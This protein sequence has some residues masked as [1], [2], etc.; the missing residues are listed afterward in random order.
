MGVV[1]TD[2][3]RFEFQE[4]KEVLVWYTAIYRPVSSTALANI[5]FP[6]TTTFH[7]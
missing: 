7:E 6:Y 4:Q 1:Y 5:I 3:C 2:K